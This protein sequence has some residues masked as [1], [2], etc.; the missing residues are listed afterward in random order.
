MLLL[1]WLCLGTRRSC[2][3]S[4]GAS[5]PGGLTLVSYPEEWRSCRGCVA[6]RSVFPSRTNTLTQSQSSLMRLKGVKVNSLVGLLL[7]SRKQWRSSGPYFRSQF[8][9]QTAEGDGG[10]GWP[11][12]STSTW[13]NLSRLKTSIHCFFLFFLFFFSF[14][15]FFVFVSARLFGRSEMDCQTLWCERDTNSLCTRELLAW[16]SLPASKSIGCS[17]GTCPPWTSKMSNMWV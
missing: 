7:C 15:Q 10:T 4:C 6:T 8:I 16:R 3:C 11:L 17:Y 12:I 9:V 2:L 5:P 1:R 13:K 14:Q